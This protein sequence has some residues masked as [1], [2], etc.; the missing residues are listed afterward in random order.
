MEYSHIT[1]MQKEAIE[2]LACMPGKIYAD[3]T[4]GGAGHSIAICKKIAPKGVLI[5]IDRDP[6]AVKNA[7]KV[8]IEFEK[9]VNIKIFRANFENIPSLLLSEGIDKVDGILADLGLSLNQIKKSKRGFGF[10][11]D[12]PLDMRMNPKNPIT[13]EHI[14]N[15]F[16]YDQLVEI[17]R[18]YGEEPLA[19]YIAEKIRFEREKEEIKSSGR[20]AD[21][22]RRA[23]Y[24]KKKT[25]GKIDPATKVFMAIRIAVNRELEILDKF[26]DTASGILN[27]NG[28]LC[29]ISFHSLE[30]R[31]VKHKIK[32]MAKKGEIRSLTKKP[33]I[34]EQAE[35]ARN[36]MARSAK[37]RAFEKL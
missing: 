8:L 32:A 19:R 3:C 12:E 17:F 24:R 37:L 15:K 29:V 25:R 22:V 33:V 18:E 30:D 14:V 35:V 9:D 5:G 27:K 26:M 34:P 11:N 10:N 23:V 28:R 16:S 21:I 7:K 6:E 31:I 4:L 20:L 13:A 36:S 2:Y 1:V